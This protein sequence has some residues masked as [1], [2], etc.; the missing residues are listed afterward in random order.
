MIEERDERC[1]LLSSRKEINC[2]LITFKRNLIDIQLCP[3]SMTIQR[4]VSSQ[5]LRGIWK[6]CN[7]IC[8]YSVSALGSRELHNNI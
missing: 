6:P 7:A 1:M 8:P 2:S 3:S 4:N 5:C